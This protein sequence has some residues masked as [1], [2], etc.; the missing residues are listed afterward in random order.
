VILPGFICFSPINTRYDLLAIN[1]PRVS[2]GKKY[3]TYTEA[4][5]FQGSDGT[6]YDDII[7]RKNITLTDKYQSV[8][9][10]RCSFSNL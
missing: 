9:L 3:R 5:N 7:S 6:K 8:Y 10:H 2:T 1:F 4:H